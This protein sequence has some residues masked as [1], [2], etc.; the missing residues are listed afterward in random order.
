MTPVLVSLAILKL[1]L[2]VLPGQTQVQVEGG[3]I[4]SREEN[5]F[6]LWT[7]FSWVGIG[8]ERK[9]KMMVRDAYIL[10]YLPAFHEALFPAKCHYFFPMLNTLE[11]REA[12]LGYCRHVTSASLSPKA[13]LS[14]WSCRLKT[15]PD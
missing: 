11:L 9:T 4:T 5:G 1:L 3:E 14:H 15:Q 6:V 12:S 2:L 13:K 10:D 8:S 7:G